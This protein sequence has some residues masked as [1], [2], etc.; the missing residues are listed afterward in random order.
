MA[1]EKLKSAHASKHAN[2]KVVGHHCG[3]C[4]VAF[5]NSQVCSCCFKQSHFFTWHNSCSRCY[6]WK[7]TQTLL[8]SSAFNVFVVHSY[9]I[10]SLVY[11]AYLLVV[12]YYAM[13]QILL[14]CFLLCCFFFSRHNT[15]VMQLVVWM[16]N[17]HSCK[18]WLAMV[19]LW[20]PLSVI[21]FFSPV[22]GGVSSL[23]CKGED[24]LKNIIS[25]CMSTS[26]HLFT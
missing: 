25:N 14:W 18:S 4:F 16:D 10:M 8:Q 1:G 12:L 11:I 20:F 21:I 24:V 6:R 9:S 19:I 22:Q 13:V 15:L 26:H 23:L 5:P 17:C 3:H 2:I 7:S